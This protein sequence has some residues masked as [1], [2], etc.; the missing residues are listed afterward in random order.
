MLD[1]STL[2]TMIAV[3]LLIAAVG[4]YGGWLL[5]RPSP[6]MLRATAGMVCL[7]AGMFGVALRSWTDRSLIVLLPN[8]LMVGGW[9][10]LLTGVRRF[11]GLPPV[12][13]RYLVPFALVYLL[14]SVF[15]LYSSR[16]DAMR[17]LVTTVW[18]GILAL[19]LAWSLAQSVSRE[20][21]PIFWG[22]ALPIAVCGMLSLTRGLYA[23]LSLWSGP[24]SGAQTVGLLLG[25]SMMA[26]AFSL[27]MGLSL[28]MNLRYRLEVE[29]LAGFDPLTGL[30]N[31]R[32]LSSRYQTAA[33]LARRSQGRVGL[34]FLDLDDFKPINDHYGHETGD[35]VLKMIA[36][37]LERCVRSS[38]FVVRFGGDEF[39]ILVDS[40][41]D[42]RALRERMQ[43][44]REAI[45]APM[46]ID[47]QAL[48]VGFSCGGAVTPPGGGELPNLIEQADADM[49]E[50][51]GT[52]ARRLA[53]ALAAS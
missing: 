7:C 40:V 21:R 18:G 52:K 31:R 8:L 3:N 23:G 29:R 33:R 45:D 49:Y 15:W 16:N 41:R 43:S 25:V 50:S 24:V 19:S 26:A 46:V 34:L 13:L 47:G 39:V 12:L 36:A 32:L 11:R 42:L 28:A 53:L 14:V 17:L 10:L 38:E 20:D 1:V 51:K 27:A 48:Y 5:S 6:G 44:L 4:L 2:I 30:P 9:I 35:R 37:R 22:M